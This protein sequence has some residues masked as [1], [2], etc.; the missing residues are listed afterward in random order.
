[1]KK[2]FGYPEYS[3]EGEKILC[4]YDNEYSDMMMDIRVYR[5]KAGT[6]RSF[7]RTGE[8]VAVLL[9]S[10]KICYEWEGN[11]QT[12]S[13][14]DVFTEGPWCVHVCTGTGVKVTAE[15]DS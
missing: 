3:P 4:T 9:L 6:S 15:T 13:R 5:M 10:G 7:C 11:S 1:M 8:E 2:V 12:V 14:K